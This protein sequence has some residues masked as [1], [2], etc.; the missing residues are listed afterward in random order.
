M[1]KYKVMLNGRNFQIPYEGAVQRVG[2]YTTRFVEANDPE[3]AE[4]QAVALVKSDEVLRSTVKNKLDNPPIIHLEEVVEV[5]DFEGVQVPGAG[6][7]FYA[8]E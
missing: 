6:Y 1:N 2:F 4:H 8:E 3:Q 5:A 7:S